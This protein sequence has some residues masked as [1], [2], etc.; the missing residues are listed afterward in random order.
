MAGSATPQP[1]L[2]IFLCVL[3]P[4]QVV[5]NGKGEA[6][7]GFTAVAEEEEP[8]SGGAAGAEQEEC[9]MRRTLAA[10]A[11]YIYTQGGSHN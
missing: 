10:H 2:I 6:T 5:V 4:L 7:A 8:C 9:L 3:H 11:D 1:L